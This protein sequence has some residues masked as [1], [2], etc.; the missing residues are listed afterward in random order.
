MTLPLFTRR[1]TL[2]LVSYKVPFVIQDSPLD[3]K[4]TP[5]WVDSIVDLLWI[6]GPLQFMEGTEI[7]WRVGEDFYHSL[8]LPVSP[9]AMSHNVA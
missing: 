9:G 2:C 8:L 5:Q 1:E 6:E 4:K 3:I 7:Q